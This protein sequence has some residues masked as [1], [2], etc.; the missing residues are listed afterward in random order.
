MGH[1]PLSSLSAATVLA[2]M[3][4]P[5]RPRLTLLIPSSDEAAAARNIRSI[6]P[7]RPTDGVYEDAFLDILGR[8]QFVA[9][10]EDGRE[11]HRLVA[12]SDENVERVTALLWDAVE[13]HRARQRPQLLP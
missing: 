13:A 3:S 2:L 7:Q 4:R 6:G 12:V 11:I 5:T 10:D 9:A 1:H 8:R